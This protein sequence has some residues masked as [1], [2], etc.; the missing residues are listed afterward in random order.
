MMGQQENCKVM[1]ETFES[2]K[3]SASD[4][5][6]RT[7]NNIASTQATLNSSINNFAQTLSSISK[8]FQEKSKALD[9]KVI[10]QRRDAENMYSKN[11]TNL[12]ESLMDNMKSF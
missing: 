3:Q 6:A 1:L 9:E 12:N 5:L 7:K 4:S 10:Q 8:D 2:L 11:E